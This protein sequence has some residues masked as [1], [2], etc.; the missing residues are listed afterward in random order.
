MSADTEE[1]VGTEEDQ[2]LDQ[3]VA[4]DAIRKLEIQ[5]YDFNIFI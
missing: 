4:T 1:R 2:D 3:V 5:S